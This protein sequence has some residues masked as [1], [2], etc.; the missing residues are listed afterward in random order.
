ME[1]GFPTSPFVSS[2]RWPWSSEERWS[3]HRRWYSL[4]LEDWCAMAWASTRSWIRPIS[5]VSQTIA[6]MGE[7]QSL[8][9]HPLCSC[10]RHGKA[11][12]DWSQRM[13]LGW[14]FLK[15]KKGGLLVGPTKKGKGIKIM[16]IGDK[17]S[18][19][20]AIC[21]ASASPHE[22][23]LVAKTL[24]SRFTKALSRRL[25]ADRAYDSDPLD[26]RL[27][28]KGIELIAP[29]KGNRVK[30]KTQDGRPL[31][32][33]KRRWKIE[34]LNA[35]LQQFRRVTVRYEYHARN[36]LSFVLLACV[37]ILM[38]NYFWDGL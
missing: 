6:R 22:V 8:W 4:D 21:V 18:L 2:K 38:R 13:F 12:Q 20:V 11:W 27:R 29:H 10:G 25:V 28:R 5:N 9:K 19:P 36:F 14:H 7:E 33:Y 31:R 30:P 17:S 34:R 1:F 37:M 3:Q 24:A 16:A 15:C 23:T 32:R 26:K 35:W